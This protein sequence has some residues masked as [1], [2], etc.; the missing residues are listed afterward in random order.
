MNR[1]N[2]F[3]ALYMQ[4][5]EAQTNDR[6][7]AGEGQTFA[8]E[9]LKVRAGVFEQ[10]F[11]TLMSF[12]LM[13]RVQGLSAEDEEYTYQTVREY[14]TTQTGSA[15]G[16][17]APAANVS[18]HEETPMKI[19][20]VTGSYEY[21]FHEARVSARLGRQL[22]QRKANAA[23]RA[24]MQEIDRI[25]T[26][27]GAASKYGVALPGLLTPTLQASPGDEGVLVY[28]VPSGLAG[29][30]LWELKT[31]DEVL[32][33]LFAMDRTVTVNSSGIEAVDSLLLPLS[34]DE[35]I[36][37]RRLGDGSNTTIKQHFLANA[38]HIKRIV[39]WYAL[40]AAPAGQWTGRRMMAYDSSSE[41][42]EY[43]M[44]VDFEQFAP[45]ISGFVTKTFAHS[46]V[47]GVVR[48][49]PKA[50]IVGDGF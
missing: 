14:G 35:E 5:A 29:S 4:W 2:Q 11:P 50:I 38:N 25:L 27:G 15:Y 32:A 40:Q 26:Y 17:D 22:Q 47:G 18:F 44:P 36:S 45:Q 43:I 9:L 13:S 42:L 6:V 3:A 23:R 20:P 28:T 21:S 8:R 31:P 24:I 37:S 41:C 16:T 19:R 48:Y 30:P 7:D 33:D 12:Q 49:R 34:A 1:M 10:K 46:R 39:P